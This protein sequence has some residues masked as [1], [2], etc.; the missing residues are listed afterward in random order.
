MEKWV[1]IPVQFGT[2]L[3]TKYKVLVPYRTT[4]TGIKSIGTV[5]VRYSGTKKLIPSSGVS[6]DSL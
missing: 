1:P 2:V 3:V 5:P 4:D 6:R